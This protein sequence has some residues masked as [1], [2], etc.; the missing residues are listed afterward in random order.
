MFHKSKIKE[1]AEER[2]EILFKEAQKVYKKRPDLANRYVQIARKISMKVNVPIPVKYKRKFCKH[3]YSYF[4]PGKTLRV[5]QHKG[6]TIY[7]CLKCKK[8]MRFK[9]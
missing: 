1:I 6:R 4:I 7:Y 2:I 8:F 9:H 3:C 5:R